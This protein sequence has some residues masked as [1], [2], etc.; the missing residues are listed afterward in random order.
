MQDDFMRRSRDVIISQILDI[1]IGGAH[2]TQIVYQANL[3]FRTVN[4]YIELLTS[5]G[6]IDA[7]KED[8]QACYKTTYKGLKLL[9]KY[10]LVQ[11]M[12]SSY[13]EKENAFIAVDF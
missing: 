8:N 4:P 13:T 7:N 10:R 6:L 11:D 2:K 3:N 1:R 5:N 12:L 9:D